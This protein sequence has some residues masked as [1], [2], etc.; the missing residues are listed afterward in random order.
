MNNILSTKETAELLGW[1]ERTF[2]NKLWSSEKA[3][4]P[5]AH[6]YGRRVY[7]V[8]DEVEQWL[9]NQPIINAPAK[10]KPGRPRKV[11]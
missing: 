5:P 8:K 7:F 9:I 2:K 4:L 11:V 6:K 3:N 1:K 10:R